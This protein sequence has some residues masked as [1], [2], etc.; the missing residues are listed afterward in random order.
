[1]DPASYLSFRL[2]EELFALD[3]SR[4]REI[5]E[6]TAIT[7]IPQSEQIPSCRSVTTANMRFILKEKTSDMQIHLP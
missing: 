2:D 1:M 3:V 4:V 6:A 5:L 7:K